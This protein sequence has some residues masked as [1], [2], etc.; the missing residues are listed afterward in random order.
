VKVFKDVPWTASHNVEV[1][2]TSHTDLERL[3][4]WMDDLGK[5]SSHIDRNDTVENNVGDVVLAKDF[6]EYFQQRFNADCTITHQ[7]HT[8]ID[9]SS[10]RQTAYGSAMS[11]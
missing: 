1:F 3:H 8:Y 6:H 4:S 10:T 7:Q 5:T 2:P 9:S 11:L